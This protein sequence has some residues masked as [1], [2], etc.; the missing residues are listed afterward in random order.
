MW[1]LLS[2][3]AT[4]AVAG[5]SEVTDSA[6]DPLAE[7]LARVSVRLEPVIQ[8]A[9]EEGNIPSITVAL[10]DRAGELWAGLYGESNLWAG[11]PASTETVYLIASTFKAQS[12]IAL[13]QQLETGL[14]QLDDPVNPYLGDFHIQEEPGYPVTFRHLLTH[15]SGL[16]T[17]Y[18]GHDVWG[19]TVPA[20]LPDYLSGALRVETPPMEKVAYSNLAL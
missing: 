10:T 12:T 7:A 16:P 15:T 6:G 8:E 4:S 1:V 9:M 13:L 17:A 11:T 14:F 5:Q 19:E 18:G 20:P 3:V 2:A